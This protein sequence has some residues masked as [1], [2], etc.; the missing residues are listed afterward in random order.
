[1]NQGIQINCFKMEAPI[2]FLMPLF[3]SQMELTKGSKTIK[4]P[5]KSI[6]SNI[7][8]IKLNDAGELEVGG[9]KILYQEIT[10]DQISRNYTT[11]CFKSDLISKFEYKQH[12]FYTPNDIRILNSY[13]AVLTGV[14]SLFMEIGHIRVNRTAEDIVKSPSLK[15][16]IDNFNF[17]INTYDLHTKRCILYTEGVAILGRIQ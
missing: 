3:K 6:I 11:F 13:F 12:V 7:V 14:S 1:M 16:N 4:K 10:S 2:Y 9:P 8:T 5:L 17:R 15:H